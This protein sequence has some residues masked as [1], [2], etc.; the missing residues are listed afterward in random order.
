LTTA[1]L[2]QYIGKL[3]KVARTTLREHPDWAHLSASGSPVWW[4]DMRKCQFHDQETK[5]VDEVNLHKDCLSDI[6]KSFT[7]KSLCK[8]NINE[9]SLH[10]NITLFQACPRTGHSANSS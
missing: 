8:G 2:V 3:L 9:L 6:K 4:H 10:P 7:A 1:T 5:D